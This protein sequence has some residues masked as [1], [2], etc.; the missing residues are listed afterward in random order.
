M[1]TIKASPAILA[2]AE[3]V[4]E[5]LAK[6]RIDFALVGGMA[7]SAWLGEE[8]SEG[9]V[10]LLAVVSPEGRQQIP[11]MASHRGF[12]LDRDLVEATAELD[13]VPMMW[14]GVRIHVLIASNALYGRMV[15]TSV[16][17]MLGTREVRVLA[18]EDLALL[19]T[20]SADEPARRSAQRLVALGPDRFELSRFNEKLDSIGLGRSRIAG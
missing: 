16:V 14:E 11:M 19:L 4:A 17:A 8:V 5:L 7:L 9:P 2:A 20:V 12:T 6:L 13:L 15:A 3:E 10:D 18:A 1:L